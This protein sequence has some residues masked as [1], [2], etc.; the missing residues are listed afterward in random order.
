MAKYKLEKGEFYHISGNTDALEIR[1][2]SANKVYTQNF[3]DK[4]L[5]EKQVVALCDEQIVLFNGDVL[6]RN[7][8]ELTIN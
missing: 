4:M 7:R 3:T 8:A 1:F 5:T 6:S 2:S